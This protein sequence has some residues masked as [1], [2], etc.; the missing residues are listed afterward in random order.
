MPIPNIDALIAEIHRIDTAPK[1]VNG[2]VM[3]DKHTKTADIVD[4]YV[5]TSPQHPIRGSKPIPERLNDLLQALKADNNLLKATAIN[6]LIGKGTITADDLK[7]IGI[8]QRFMQALD[9]GWKPQS[10]DAPELLEMIRRESTEVY[11]WGIPS[12][13]KSCAIGAIISMAAA[14]KASMCNCIFMD[15]N[16]QGYNYMMRLQNLFKVDDRVTALPTGTPVLSTYEMGFDLVDHRDRVHPITFIDLAGEL[17]RCMFKSD[18]KRPLDND[19]RTALEILDKILVDDRTQNQK[20]HFFVL[21]YG[22]ENREYEGLSQASYLAGALNYIREK[23]IF[24]DR[25]DGI[26]L[27]ITK[28]DKANMPEEELPDYLMKYIYNVHGYQGFAQGLKSLC[29]QYNINNGDLNVFPFSLGK[30]CFKDYCIFDGRYTEDI[31]T[32]LV[33]RTYCHSSSK[34][35]RFFHKLLKS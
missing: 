3:G 28:A 10:F 25:T 9:Q 4:E 34:I 33:K 27:L 11:F 20:L 7:G 23:G 16:C 5:Y 15:N 29:K 31:I 24:R 14:S 17:I 18:A 6:I 32:E 2:V 22:G 12:S 30:V 1:V 19:E 21:E 8:D 13:G 26:Y 35:V